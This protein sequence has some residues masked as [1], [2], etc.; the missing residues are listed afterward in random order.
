MKNLS[1][2][3][4]E[5]F[6]VVTEEKSFSLAAEKLGLTQGALS[7]RVAKLEKELDSR[8]FRR[9]TH[10]VELTESGWKVFRYCQQV[11][12]LERELLADLN[13]EKSE[14]FQGL[15][16]IVAKPM[17]ISSV[18]QP[19]LTPL[20]RH[21]DDLDIAFM[22]EN[23]QSLEALEREEV[24]FVVTDRVF[25]R[26]QIDSYVLGQEHFVM[27][28][29]ARHSVPSNIYLDFSVD[30]TYLFS[31]LNREGERQPN[32][33]R[34]FFVDLP[35]LLAALKQGLGRA[36]LPQQVISGQSGLRQVES[37]DSKSFPVIL[38]FMKKPVHSKMHNA[39]IELLASQ[40]GRYL[41]K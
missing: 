1:S 21:H 13:D 15:L 18:I 14:S 40:S 28:E 22:A 37:F 19:V 3:Q 7:Q 30:S 31:L 10:G 32:V 27:V 38:N 26:P 16:K 4:L 34:R 36:V 23:S 24:H 11:S 35:A 5:A 25:E 29:S 8:L 20:L 6:R 9:S 33:R 2:S 41:A 12:S 17:L 39:V